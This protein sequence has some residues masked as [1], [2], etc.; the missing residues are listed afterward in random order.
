MNKIVANNT[1]T[2]RLFAWSAIAILCTVTAVVADDKAAEKDLANLQGE[3]RMVSGSANGM[4][5][6]EEMARNFK[7]VCKDDVTTV[8]N[9]EQTFMKAKFKLDASKSPKTI[10]YEF[11]DGPTKG[12]TQLGIYE[13]DGDTAK[14]AFGAPG[15]DR[16]TDF[17]SKPGDKRTVSVWKRAKPD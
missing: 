4:S 3:W 6:T 17:S 14:F 15:T 16:P 13:L 5:L 1:A 10:D 2:A 11:L 12:K 7:R 8:S 9:G